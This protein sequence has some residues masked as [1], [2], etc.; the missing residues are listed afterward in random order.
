MKTR[1]DIWVEGYEATGQSSPAQY[2]GSAEGVTFEEAVRAWYEKHPS[3]SFDPQMLTL[4]GCRHF[5]TEE[6]ARRSFG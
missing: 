5:P 2:I 6:E 1:F 4:W 3:S